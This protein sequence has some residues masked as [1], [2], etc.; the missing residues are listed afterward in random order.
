MTHPDYCFS[1]DHMNNCTI[2]KWGESGY[3]MTDYP[4]GKYTNEIIDEMNSDRG[5]T[6]QQKEAMVCCSIAAQS[7][8]NLDWED[9]YS[10]ILEMEIERSK[11]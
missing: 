9:H 5:V 8:P 7:N 4:K 11:R 10:M 2:I 1:N 3:Y 6:P